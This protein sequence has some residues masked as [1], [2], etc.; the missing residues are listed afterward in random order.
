MSRALGFILAYHR[1]AAP[2]FD[3]QR[4]RVTPEHFSQQLQVLRS[5]ATPCSLQD[6]ALSSSAPGTP[7]RVAVTLDDGYADA[8]LAGAPLLQAAA[9]PATIFVTTGA[10]GDPALFWW[11]VLERSLFEPRRLPAVLELRQGE[12]VESFE[13]GGDQE[14]EI[15]VAARAWNVDDARD[16]T[17]R[18]RAYRRLHAILGAAPAAQRRDLLDAICHWAGVPT[19]PPPGQGPLTTEQLQS[20]ARS[21][22]IE[23][24]AHTQGHVRLSAL[25]ARAQHKEMTSSRSVLHAILDRPPRSMAYPYG[26]PRDI[27]RMTA[28][29]ARAAGYELAC[30]GVGGAVR[31]PVRRWALPRILAPDLGAAEFEHWLDVLF[32][33][34]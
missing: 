34:S 16:P 2:G 31:A 29:L 8:W 26:A 3:P 1:I 15:P 4:L 10:I 5:R 23:I 17:P 21:P 14:Q 24:G 22:G 28:W 9:I 7:P 20:L 19:A 25:S 30:L 6:L 32:K 13:F 27:S 33:A 11:D 18:H 12:R